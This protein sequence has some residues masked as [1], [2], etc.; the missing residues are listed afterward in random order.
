VLAVIPS[1]PRSLLDRLLGLCFTLLLMA[2]AI[3]VSVRLIEAV[4][5]VLIGIGVGVVAVAGLVTVLRW[6]RQGW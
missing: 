1:R 5:P 3:H 6:R 2:I 4:W